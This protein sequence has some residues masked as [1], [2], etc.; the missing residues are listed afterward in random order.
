LSNAVVHRIRQLLR[1]AKSTCAPE[2]AALARQRAAELAKKHGIEIVD[3][4]N[5]YHEPVAGVA[6]YYWRQRLLAATSLSR[7]CRVFR[8]KKTG[9]MVVSGA[10]RDVEE[11]TQLYQHL[12]IE[13]LQLAMRGW[14]QFVAYSNTG[15]MVDDLLEENDENK[16]TAA[17]YFRAYLNTIVDAINARLVPPAEIYKPPP[18]YDLPRVP[19]FQREKTYEEQEKD[20]FVEEISKLDIYRTRSVLNAV[21]YQA[22]SDYLMLRLEWRPQR[23]LTA[24]SSFLPKPKP[25]P[26][27]NRFNQLDMD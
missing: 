23:L 4:D 18:K 5:E 16:L 17:V 11:A 26:A 15:Y 13:V 9:E 6:G 22:R 21:K 25:K 3:E 19:G 10:K 8:R 12:H 7:R 14:S 20:L 2:E 24:S 1:L 27:P